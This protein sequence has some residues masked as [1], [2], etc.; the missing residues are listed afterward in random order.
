MDPTLPV[1]ELGRHITGMTNYSVQYVA[2][3]PEPE[4]LNVSQMGLIETF[5]D[6]YG[7]N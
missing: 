7:S 3:E 4:Y 6:A 5:N 1:G 2:L